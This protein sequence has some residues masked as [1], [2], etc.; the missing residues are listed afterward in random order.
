MACSIL[1]S[2]ATT[3]M[4]EEL[5]KTKEKNVFL[6]VFGGMMQHCGVSFTFEPHL[7]EETPNM[8]L[9]L[10]ILPIIDPDRRALL[11]EHRGQKR[12]GEIPQLTNAKVHR[13]SSVAA[14]THAI[15]PMKT[16]AGGSLAVKTGRKVEKWRIV[17][18]RSAAPLI[19]RANLHTKDESGGLRLRQHR[20]PRSCRRGAAL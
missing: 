19:W 15:P 4:P 14:G 10:Y 16:P 5:Q 18:L 1:L 13:H 17:E 20:L 8:Y 2:M 11:R 7:L 9:Y 3:P 12:Y 6:F